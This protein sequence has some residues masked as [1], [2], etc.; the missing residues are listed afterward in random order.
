M[1]NSEVIENKDVLLV[2]DVV[3]TGAT[4]KAG[5]PELLKSKNVHLSIAT[6]CFCFHWCIFKG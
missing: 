6:L 3:T 4:L 5:G 2:D 1:I